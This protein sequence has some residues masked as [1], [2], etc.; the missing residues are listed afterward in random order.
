M[1]KTKKVEELNEQDI[2]GA[3]SEYDPEGSMTKLFKILYPEKDLKNIDFVS[4][5]PSDTPAILSLFELY[6]EREGLE[7]FKEFS[8]KLKRYMVSKD[9]KGRHEALAMINWGMKEQEND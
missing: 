4:E 5:L 8:G 7:D 3:V 2:I 6:A 9:R 1:S